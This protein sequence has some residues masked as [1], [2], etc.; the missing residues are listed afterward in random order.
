MKVKLE[1]EN[2]EYLGWEKSVNSLGQRYSTEK[3]NE[4]N[5]AQNVISSAIFPDSNLGF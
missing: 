4:P 2:P 1:G 5:V 3:R